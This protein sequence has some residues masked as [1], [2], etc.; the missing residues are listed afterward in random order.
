M[1][2]FCSYGGYVVQEIRKVTAFFKDK[3]DSFK[4]KVL[5]SCLRVLVAV[6]KK[7]DPG[8]T[9]S[10]RDR[11]IFGGRVHPP[12]GDAEFFARVAD[13]QSVPV[14]P[15]TGP[16]TSESAKAVHSM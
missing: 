7:L 2:I 10:T 9:Y 11:L 4:L 15:A 6:H 5:F 13:A 14:V 12:Y 3:T 8:K 1:V 16:P